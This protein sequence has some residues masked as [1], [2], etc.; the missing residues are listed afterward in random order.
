MQPFGATARS[1]GGVTSRREPRAETASRNAENVG[2]AVGIEAAASRLPSFKP[3]GDRPEGLAMTGTD[4]R[5]ATGTCPIRPARPLRT[6]RILG[7]EGEPI[8]KGLSNRRGPF[9]AGCVAF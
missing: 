1:I 6:P 9:R 2:P 5:L 3:S 8:I 7:V 4:G